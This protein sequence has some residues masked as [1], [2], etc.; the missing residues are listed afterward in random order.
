LVPFHCNFAIMIEKAMILFF[1]P[2]IMV[3]SSL[4][5][6]LFEKNP[7]Q[8]VVGLF[9]HNASFW[10]HIFSVISKLYGGKLLFLFHTCKN[11]YFLYVQIVKYTRLAKLDYCIMNVN[12]RSQCHFSQVILSKM[13]I[14]ENIIKKY[15]SS[16][17]ELSIASFRIFWNTCTIRLS[18]RVFFA[19]EKIPNCQLAKI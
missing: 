17:C 4:V 13:H 8:S 11:N 10:L 14:K 9:P 5:K 16:E 15:S 18:R 1:S 6:I 3:F 7:V 2:E 19:Q 12:P